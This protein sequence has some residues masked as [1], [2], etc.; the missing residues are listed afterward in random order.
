MKQIFFKQIQEQPYFIYK[1]INNKRIYTNFYKK[2][3]FQIEVNKTIRDLKSIKDEVFEN[4]FNKDKILFFEN[5]MKLKSIKLKLLQNSKNLIKKFIFTKSFSKFILKTTIIKLKKLKNKNVSLFRNL[6]HLQNE[7]E[8]LLKGI[9]SN[10][11]NEKLSFDN[12]SYEL[13]I[14]RRQNDNLNKQIKE[15]EFQIKKDKEKFSQLFSDNVNDI[16]SK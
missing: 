1:K 2:I 13:D 7:N 12:L 3:K 4:N 16:R 14:T 10:K 6:E 5:A 9:E 8:N 15:L 11:M